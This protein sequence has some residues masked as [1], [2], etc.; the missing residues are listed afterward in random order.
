MIIKEK[1]KKTTRKE[2]KHTRKT[3]ETSSAVFHQPLDVRTCVS[4]RMHTCS[5]ICADMYV[6]IC[7]CVSTPI[8]CIS[9]CACTEMYVCA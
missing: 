4:T 9:T 3:K 5:H 2:E 8:I 6:H 7:A 1:Y